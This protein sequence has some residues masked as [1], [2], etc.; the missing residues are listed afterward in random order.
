MFEYPSIPG[1]KKAPNSPCFA[2]VKYDG[3]NVRFEWSKKKGFHK[4]GTRTRLF[5]ASDIQLGEAYTTFHKDY[6]EWL[7][8]HL[9]ETLNFKSRVTVF[10]EFF[11]PNSFA[12]NHVKGEPKEMRLF[13]VHDGY[14]FIK[15]KF[16][17]GMFGKLHYAA[18]CIY[19][20][21]FNK[22]FI[23]KIRQNTDLVEGVVV[24]GN[25]WMSKVKT[26]RYLERLR[27]VY[28]TDYVKYWE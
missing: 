6:A 2:Y 24:K 19:E 21:N 14:E 17:N 26:N 10:L 11:G 12:G 28:T 15:P 5:D 16:F 1:P 27:Q 18:E 22:E 13:D 23:E 7:H 20:G 3:S 4:A 25:G 8:V 9:G